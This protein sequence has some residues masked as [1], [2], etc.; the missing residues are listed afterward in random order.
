MVVTLRASARIKDMERM[1]LPN[2]RENREV[3]TRL[4]QG[5]V[6][7]YGSEAGEKI[8]WVIIDEL[9]GLRMVVPTNSDR[10]GR[11]ENIRLINCLYCRLKKEFGDA[12]GK[13]IMQKFIQELKSMRISFPDLQD[14]AREDRDRRIRQAHGGIPEIALRFGLSETQIWRIRNEE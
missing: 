6:N 14:L 12:S 2:R 9:G 10:S 13:A 5:Y 3:L 4:F 7:D 11:D 8:I 1:Q